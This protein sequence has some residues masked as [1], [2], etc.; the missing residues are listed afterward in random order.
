MA[1][2]LDASLRC[3]SPQRVLP[4]ARGRRETAGDWVDDASEAGPQLLLDTC[5]IIDV[6]QGRSP[7]AVDRLLTTRLCNHSTIVLTE[8]TYLF[9]RLEPALASTRQVLDEISG[10][11]AD[12]PRHRLS[13]P[14]VRAFGEAGMLA[15]LVA[16]RRAV[17]RRQR[18]G[19]IND[20]LIYC[21]AAEQGHT[22]LTANRND[23][24]LFT[25]FLPQGRVLYYRP[26]ESGSR[27]SRRRHL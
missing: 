20:A 17:D 4:S 9:G 18:H 2:E 5:V 25:H 6:L 19:L 3:V 21:Q 8:L 7:D 15:G 1:F 23:F 14:S 24:S 11:I 10:V 13:G 26:M 12:I 27:R 22:V 16:R